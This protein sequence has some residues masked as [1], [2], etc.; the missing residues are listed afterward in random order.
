MKFLPLLRCYA[1]LIP[2][3]KFFYGEPKTSDTK[4]YFRRFIP[5]GQELGV[6]GEP[7]R[8]KAPGGPL[9]HSGESI[10]CWGGDWEGL[11]ASPQGIGA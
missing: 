8:G 10:R 3:I 4:R 1:Q 9:C 2:E 7:E 6:G 5:A 11:R